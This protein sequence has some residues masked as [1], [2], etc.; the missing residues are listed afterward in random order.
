M[1]SLAALVPVR[2][3]TDGKR[4]L[5]TEFNPS[6]RRALVESMA[7]HVVW[8]LIHS[9][10]VSQVMVIS[11]DPDFIDDVLPDIEGTALIHQPFNVA[12]L[13]AALDLGREWALMR[14][15]S[16]LLIVSGDLPLLT[17]EDVRALSQRSSAVVLASDRA[18]RGTNGLLLDQE[19]APSIDLIRDFAFKFGVDSLVRH[20][21]ETARLGVSAEVVLRRGT[22]HDLDTP[23][24]WRILHPQV[25]EQLLSHDR[26]IERS[27][28]LAHHSAVSLAA[29]ERS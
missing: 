4:R 3:R 12:G 27:T 18:G 19:R 9:G 13:N 16:R 28:T 22:G 2:N 17:V 29:M 1:R 14:Q 24:D 25:R 21:D 20:M 26:C 15:V 6:E 5:S 7:Q 11:K 23:D 8:T 10:A